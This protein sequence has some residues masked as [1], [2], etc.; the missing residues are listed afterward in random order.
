MQVKGVKNTAVGYM[1][2]TTKN[3]T[4]EQVCANKTG[5]AE[6]TQ[7]EYDPKEVS[8]KGLLKVFWEIHDP[9]TVDRQ[10]PDVGSQYRS[11]IFYH[12]PEQKRL[13]EKSKEEIE[14]SG[15]YE[16]PIVTAIEPAGTFWK[17]EEYHQQYVKKTGIR[18]C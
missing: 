17:A 7:V 14:A 2:G 15:K 16:E 1:G 12:T 3:P 10:G 9:T 13:A 11:V 5:H 4:Y 8:Y 18:V 6:V